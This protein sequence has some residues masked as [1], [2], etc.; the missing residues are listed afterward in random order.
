MRRLLLLA[1]LVAL[2][3]LAACGG[4]G[5]RTPTIEV[6]QCFDD[7]ESDEVESFPV[8]DCDEP[9]DNEVF[10]VYDVDA[11][12][13]YPGTDALHEEGVERCTGEPFEAYV[14]EPY[15]TSRFEVFTVVPT[16]TSWGDGD[17]EVVCALYDPEDQ[18]ETGSARSTTA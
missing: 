17:R 12:G 1:A 10:H 9:H 15:E 18:T 13:D 14:G 16:E 6:G 7:G 3:A 2:V 5:G 8:V 11:D 4:G